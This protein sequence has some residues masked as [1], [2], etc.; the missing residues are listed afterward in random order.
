[1]SHGTSLMPVPWVL[2]PSL[3]WMLPLFSNPKCSTPSNN[4]GQLQDN[5]AGSNTWR[6]YFQNGRHQPR[7][8]LTTRAATPT[9]H[10][11]FFIAF[12]LVRPSRRKSPLLLSPK[13]NFLATTYKILPL[14]HTKRHPRRCIYNNSP[15]CAAQS[16]PMAVLSTRIYI[17]S[18]SPRTLSNVST[19]YQ[20]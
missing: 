15:S 13:T 6:Y 3:T 8:S 2:A 16:T 19:L 10:I 4:Y 20:R 11:G 9:M 1:M 17:I 5:A 7:L 14:L 12:V 18:S